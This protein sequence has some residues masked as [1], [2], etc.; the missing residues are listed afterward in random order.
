MVVTVALQ[1]KGDW[2]EGHTGHFGGGFDVKTRQKGFN[3]IL[4]IFEWSRKLAI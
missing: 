1:V 4:N 3:R 2:R